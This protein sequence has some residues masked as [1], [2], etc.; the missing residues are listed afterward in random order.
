MRVASMPRRQPPPP[1]AQVL[2]FPAPSGGLNRVDAAA[3]MPPTDCVLAYNVIAGADGLI[4]RPGSR[5]WVTGLTG[6]A[7]NQVRTVIAF[8]G[9]AANGANDRLFVATSSGIWDVSTSTTSPSQ[10]IAF[11][12]SAGKAGR[13]VGIVMVTLAGHFLVYADEENGLYLYTESSGTWTKYAMG[14][15]AGQIAGVDPAN[16]CF[17]TVFKG[18][19]W[20]VER[21]TARAWYLDTGAIA[22]TAHQFNFGLEFR[23]GGPLVCLANWTIDGG[24]G[25]DDR[26]VAISGGGDVA[27]YQGIDPTS[28]ALFGLVGV[29]YAGSLVAGRRIVT[30]YGG[31][32]AILTKVGMLPLSKLV[33]GDPEAQR[34]QYATAKVG[35]LWAALA[36]TAAGLDGW[37][38]V[39]HPEEN[40][41]MVT[42]PTTDGAATEQFVMSLW[43]RS[44]YRYRALPIFSAESWGGKLYFGT[45]DG[46]VLVHDGEVDGVTLADPNSST[47][48]DYSLITSFQGGNDARQ[49]RVTLIR[50]TLLSRTTSPSYT[51]EARYRYDMTEVAPQS[52]GTGGAGTFG[53]AVWDSATWGSDSQA[54]QAASGATGMGVEFAVAIRGAATTRTTFVGADVLFDVGGIL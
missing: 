7:N 44:W 5:E 28:A 19:L 46:R 33:A 10:A 42:V 43:N 12:S 37:S 31:D 25:V 48:V 2:R 47:P 26:L 27:I 50:P 6:A 3:S 8:A 15:D 14:L 30:N 39:L 54:S 4:T 41:L 16:I 32:V 45:I 22:G 13:G 23:A 52:A 20:L 24:S 29:W 40:A 35:P 9:S 51:A 18:R 21:D 17:V 1:T 34:S 53:T 11:P 36:A 49:K 38:M